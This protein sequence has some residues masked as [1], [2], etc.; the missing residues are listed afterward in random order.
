[1][2]R[3]KKVLVAFSVVAAVTAVSAPASAGPLEEC[4]DVDLSK[5]GWGAMTICV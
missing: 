5:Y 1:M 2:S 3:F 4:V